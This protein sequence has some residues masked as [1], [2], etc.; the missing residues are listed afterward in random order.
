M[1][2]AYNEYVEMIEADR[3]PALEL[4]DKAIRSAE[5]GFDCR[6]AYKMLMYT[7]NGDHKHWICAI[8][9]GRSGMKGGKKTGPARMHLRFLF[10]HLLDDPKDLLRSGTGILRT[11]DFPLDGEFDLASVTE[12]VRDAVSKL[13]MFI[14]QS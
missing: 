1:N 5:D 10:G 4:L 14:S 2:N 9:V 3:V 11:I 8:D 6:I 13:D 7:L 12:Y